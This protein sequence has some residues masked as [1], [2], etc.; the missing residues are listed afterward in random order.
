MS[1]G[2]P[3]APVSILP[4]LPNRLEK[5]TFAL[6]GARARATRRQPIDKP[7][8]GP[9]ARGREAVTLG[10]PTLAAVSAPPIGAAV[11]G[12]ETLPLAEPA[13]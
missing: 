4:R 13:E 9:G 11:P 10:Q 3:E 5:W 8:G 7:H 2:K 12:G 1:E 6:S